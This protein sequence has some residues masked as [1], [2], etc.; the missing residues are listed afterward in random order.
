[1]P[2]LLKHLS[3]FIPPLHF[4]SRLLGRPSAAHITQV[5]K[6][7][8]SAWM[9]HSVLI[10]WLHLNLARSFWLTSPEERPPYL[11]P[12][13]CLTLALA[14]SVTRGVLPASF[15]VLLDHVHC[16]SAWSTDVCLWDPFSPTLLALQQ[17]PALPFPY[18][19]ARC[20]PSVISSFTSLT[21]FGI[22]LRS[23][24]AVITL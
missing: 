8:A 16:S 19:G 13:E 20:L 3:L 1:M 24:G 2:V 17:P 18:K 12:A 23:P 7:K 11:P 21:M 15:P 14:G 9:C 22:F 4:I 10:A 5:H 6:N